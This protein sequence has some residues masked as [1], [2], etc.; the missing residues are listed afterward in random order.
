[1]PPPGNVSADALDYYVSK[2]PKPNHSLYSLHI[3]PK[4]VTSLRCPSPRHSAKAKQLTT[5]VYVE[6]V[7]NRLPRCVRFGRSLGIELSTSRT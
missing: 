6:A 3:T 1:L 5:C 7:A 2:T 4:C